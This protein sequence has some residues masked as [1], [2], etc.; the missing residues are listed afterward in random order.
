MWKKFLSA[1]VA[2]GAFVALCWASGCSTTVTETPLGEAGTGEGGRPDRVVPEGGGDPDTGPGTCPKAAPTSADLDANGGWKEP[3]AIQKNACSAS[4][5]A[6]FKSNFSSAKTW[7]DLVNGLPAGCQTCLYSHEA[8]ANWRVIV[9]DA[10]DQAGFVNFGACYA[11]GPG[12]TAGCGKA[13]QYD[14][15]CVTVSCNDCPDADFQSCSQSKA[16]LSACDANFRTMISSGCGTDA[17][18]LQAL[19]DACGSA[20]LAAKVLCGAGPGDGGGGG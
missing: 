9:A 2:S 10:T 14:E 17:A 8:D 6:T 7:K 18:K 4:D 15:F 5:L 20:E 19:D 11:V 12:G 13:V 16:T 3:G 1:G